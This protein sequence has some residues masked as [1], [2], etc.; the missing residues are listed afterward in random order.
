MNRRS[1]PHSEP[2]SFPLSLDD[3][4]GVL[5]V[6]IAVSGVLLGISCLQGYLFHDRF[7][8]EPALIKFVISLLV[9]LDIATFIFSVHAIYHYTF[10]IGGALEALFLPF[11]SLKVS[12]VLGHTLVPI[13]QTMYCFRLW[14]LSGGDWL[15]PMIVRVRLVMMDV[16]I[17][18][19][20]SFLEVLNEKVV[21]IYWPFSA[22]ILV[23]TTIAI[24]TCYYL[25]RTRSKSVPL[26]SIVETL[27]V[28]VLGTG[29]LTTICAILILVVF[30]VEPD[31]FVYLALDVCAVKIY[32]N[33]YLAMY[34][35]LSNF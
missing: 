8:N 22:A 30:L 15:V 34:A 10:A 5:F 4:Y 17:I 23:D 1:P 19:L 25:H 21:L 11:W 12:F 16:R 28:W 18:E 14:K 35:A 24:S 9:T 26:R 3:T 29:A 33:S 31:T 13:V 20:Q 27:I 6:G 32:L 2:M 7:P